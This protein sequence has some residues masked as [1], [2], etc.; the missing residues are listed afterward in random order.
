MKK[1]NILTSRVLNRSAKEVAG[2]RRLKR[3]L[4]ATLG[5]LVVLLAAVYL[6]TVLYNK[7][8]SFTVRISKLDN[9]KYSLALSEERNFNS[10][11]ARLNSDVTEDI[12]NIR[13]IDL[14]T[15]LDSEQG[16]KKYKSGDNFVAY[17]YFV[18]NSGTAPCNMQY[19][20]Y[21]ANMTLGIEEAIR[22]RL[23]VD[24]EY[25]DYA[26]PAKDGS[27]EPGTTPFLSNQD[28]V[29]GYFDNMPVN[30]T[31]RFT[32]VIWLDGDDPECVNNILGGQFK[33]DMTINVLSPDEEQSGAVE[34]Q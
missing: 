20:L 25:T 12:T 16:G 5:L 17:T 28:V 26:W 9:L 32:V 1:E 29:V 3:F 27:A 30:K 18:K 8:G 14:P 13:T 2:Y 21:I 6:V 34:I 31:H 24:G 22:I 7:Y 15:D 23:Y 10:S 4:L 19:T 33:V 11:S